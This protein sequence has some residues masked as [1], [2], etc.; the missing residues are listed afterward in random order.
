MIWSIQADSINLAGSTPLHFACQYCPPGKTF[1]IIKLLQHKAGILI[2]NKEG[3][4]AFDLAV[5]YNRKGKVMVHVSVCVREI[6]RERERVHVSVCIREI[7]RERDYFISSLPSLVEAVALLVDAE[8]K[9]LRNIKTVLEAAKK[10]EHHIDSN[11]STN[12]S[13]TVF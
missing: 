12:P 6:K 10:G 9:L 7:E 13:Y 8:P 4:S 5:R 11:M 1:T 3:D 2:I